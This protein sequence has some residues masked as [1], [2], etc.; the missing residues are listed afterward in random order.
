MLFIVYMQNRNPYL[1]KVGTGIGT[2]KNSYGF[3]TLP[4]S[5]IHNWALG[6]PNL[7]CCAGR[8]LML[9]VRL[10]RREPLEYAETGPEVISADS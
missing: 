2:V 8:I 9:S 6:W 3:A 1:S 5:D 7:S 10:W 4:P